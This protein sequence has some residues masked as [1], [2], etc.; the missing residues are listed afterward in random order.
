MTS[1]PLTSRGPPPRRLVA[2]A[3]DPASLEAAAR[4]TDTPSSSRG[5][6]KPPTRSPGAA[7]APEVNKALMVAKVGSVVGPLKAGNAWV[8]AVVTEHSTADPKKFVEEK[9]SFARTQ[10][11]QSAQEVMDDYAKRRRAILDKEKKVFFNQE[12]LD[13]MEPAGGRQTG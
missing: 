13:Q 10:R 12:L 4:R 5:S 9:D 7:K 2:A 1:G 3:K 6:P 8:V 11:D